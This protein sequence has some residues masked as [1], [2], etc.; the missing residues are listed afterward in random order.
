MAT[1]TAPVIVDNFGARSPSPIDEAPQVHADHQ[2]TAD[3]QGPA[4]QAALGA[5][6]SAAMLDAAAAGDVSK[7]S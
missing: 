6:M 5:A 4:F 2:Q 1:A 3:Q 7:R